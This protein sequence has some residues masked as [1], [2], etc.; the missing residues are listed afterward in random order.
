[1]REKNRNPI[2]KCRKKLPQFTTMNVIDGQAGLVNYSS[3]IFYSLTIDNILNIIVLLILAGVTIATLTGDNGILTRASE[4]AE[5]TG[6]ANAEEQVQIAVAGSIGRDGN[7]DNDDLR[8]NLNQIQGIE[9][10]P[11]PITDDSYPFTVTVDG[12]PVKISKDGTVKK[13]GKWAEITNTEGETVITDGTTELK[14]GDYVN[15]DPTNGGAITDTTENG[16]NYSYKSPAGTVNSDIG[17]DGTMNRGNGY[18]DQY[19]SV[20]TNTNGWRV[21]GIDEDTDEILLISADTVGPVSG[22]E[23]YEGQTYFYLRGQTGYQYGVDELKA[24]CAIYGKGTGASGARS[25]DVDDINKITGYDPNNTGDGKP[26]ED[27][28]LWEYGNQVTYTNNGSSIGYSGTNGISSQTSPYNRF[29]YYDERNQLWKTLVNTGNITLGNTG[30]YYNPITL[31][32]S[33]D[34]S[35][36]TAGID[37]DSPEYEMLFSRTS[38][39]QEYWLAS[40]WISTYGG[41]AYFG[42]RGV[43]NGFVDYNG[44]FHSYGNIYGITYYGVRP[45]VSLESD[46]SI[47]EGEGTSV[48]TAHQIQ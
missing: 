20:T 48:S 33:D 47:T 28:K 41:Y 14:I 18:R 13:P 6:E 19:F 16:I 22:R 38:S 7:I 1:M 31:T 15:Y 37:T 4:A 29:R 21:L 23:E 12:Y 43:I 39:G 5:K 2:E 17:E 36:G 24:I 32:T 3:L 26:Y 42:L 8:D 34:I 10:V 11:N 9:D 27:G 46:I 44:L 45:V 30:Y 35:S 40:P 25:I